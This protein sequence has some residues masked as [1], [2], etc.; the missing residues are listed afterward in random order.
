[1][2][3]P[4]DVRWSDSVYRAGLMCRECG[5]VEMH[6]LRYAG[7]ILATSTCLTCGALVRH[8]ES[9]LRKA[10]LRDLESRLR[11][12][13]HR[14]VK[15]VARHPAE[16]ISELPSAIIH[17]PA[18]LL[19]EARPLITALAERARLTGRANQARGL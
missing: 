16:F 18:R 5:D 4:A 19:E 14:M 7:R 9:D 15:R 1:M 10:Y 11:T 17:K 2:N 6:E 3:M 12:K 13:P 8:D